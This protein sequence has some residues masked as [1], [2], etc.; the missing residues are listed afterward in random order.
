MYVAVYICIFPT[1]LHSTKA[2]VF[3]IAVIRKLRKHQDLNLHSE[4]QDSELVQDQHM[5]LTQYQGME[6]QHQE[7]QHQEMELN[8]GAKLD[9]SKGMERAKNKPGNRAN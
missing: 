4:A 2:D 5:G 6:A 7:T 3:N 9:Q 8:R 1:I